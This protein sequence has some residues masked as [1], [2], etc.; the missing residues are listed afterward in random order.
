MQFIYFNGWLRHC[1][2]AC[3][4]PLSSYVVDNGESK[5]EGFAILEAVTYKYCVGCFIAEW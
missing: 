2:F 1:Y 3:Q 5:M 4:H